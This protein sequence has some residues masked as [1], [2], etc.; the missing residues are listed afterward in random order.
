MKK[1]V[2]LSLFIILAFTLGSL[3]LASAAEKPQYG[4]TI[5]ICTIYPTLNALTW[6]PYDWGWKTNHDA[7]LYMEHLLV[8]DLQKGP[9]GTN[10]YPF[11]ADAHI[12]PQFVKGELAE[13]WKLQNDPLAIVFKIRKGIMWQEKKGVMKARELTA[14][15]VVFSMNRVMK[16]PKA[17]PTYMSFID[18]WET[19]DK[20]TAVCYLKEFNANWQYRFA[21]GY[22]NSIVPREMVEAG[23][24]NWRNAC[25]T[26]PYMITKYVKGVSQTYTRNKN[27]WDKAV[28]DGKKYQL[29]FADKVVYHIIKDESTRL[30]AIR[31]A[32]VDVMEGVSWKYVDTLK[33][34][35]PKLKVNKWV[36]TSGVFMAMRTDTK[37]FDD[38]RV[39]R[40]MNL[41]VN[42]QEIID[43]FYKGN[44]ELL[45]Y[46]FATTWAGLFTPLE[47]Q[48]ESI[49]ELFTYNPQK[50]KELLA[51]AG[52]SNGFTFEAMASASSPEGLDMNSMVAAYLKDVGV[53]CNIKPLEYGAFL[54]SMTKKK[55]SPG[56]FLGSG[57]TNPFAVLRK[58]FLTG[59]TWNPS[60]FSDKWFDETWKAALANTNVD[61]Q[62]VALKKLNKYALEQAPYIWL[63]TANVFTYWWPWIKNYYGEIRVGAVRPGPIYARMWLD[64]DLQKKMK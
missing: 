30:A 43:T 15:D 29:P 38:I 31:T 5:R 4:G 35:A 24:K 13:S 46:P 39:R 48:P 64:K 9:R 55:H 47:K 20:Y 50:A 53:T 59:Q 36:N 7:S 51:E 54:S 6:D 34:K 19:K 41:A 45:N 57:H 33:E 17:I 32:K 28:I 22:Y 10:E 52:Y 61:E 3:A 27:Y 25:G 2:F 49:K 18:H 14:D 21:W 40:A 1:K 63:P 42:Q 56:Y 8:G 37:P 11:V 16:S 58:N 23:P 44:A 62:T 60:M 12:P 26:G